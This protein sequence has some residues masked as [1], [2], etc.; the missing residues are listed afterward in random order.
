MAEY[1]TNTT[2]L[3]KIA[4]AIQEKGGTSDLLVYP[5][6]FVTAIGTFRLAWRNRGGYRRPWWRMQAGVQSVTA[7]VSLW[8]WLRIPILLLSLLMA[9]TGLKL[10]CLLP[11][12]GTQS[13]MAMVS[14]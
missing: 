7:M 13:V 11:Q 4:S 6:G 12:T 5:D 3:T 10:H 2:D 14:L 8:L 1:L 9:L